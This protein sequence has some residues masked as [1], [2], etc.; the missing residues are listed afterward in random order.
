MKCPHCGAD[1]SVEETRVYQDVFLRRARKCFNGHRFP[2]YEVHAGN[3]DRRTLV[4][5]R[6]GVK[7]KAKSWQIKLRILAQPG[8]AA[9]GVA[10]ELGVS[11]TYVHMVRKNARLQRL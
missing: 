7:A 9:T 6:R 10:A 3:I 4:G 2:T 5:T 1:S 8:A 11:D